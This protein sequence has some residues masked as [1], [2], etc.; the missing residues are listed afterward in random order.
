LLDFI[1]AT[2]LE[3]CAMN[4]EIMVNSKAAILDWM[5]G[6]SKTLGW[7]AL[8]AFDRATINTIFRERYIS[9]YGFGDAFPVISSGKEL[10]G[11]VARFF[12]ECVLGAPLLSFE[13]ADIVAPTASGLLEMN[14]LSGREMTID[15]NNG[16]R[17][18]KISQINALN[19]PLLQ[20]ELALQKQSQIGHVGVIAVD[21]A[22]GSKYT[23][24]SG[25]TPLET[26]LTGDMFKSVINDWPARLKYWVLNRVKL[27]SGPL[28][29]DTFSLRTQTAPGATDRS[30]ENYGDGAV[31]AFIK[32]KN[33]AAGTFPSS[34]SQLKYLIPSDDP[35]PYT[36]TTVVKAETFL[37]VAF[38]YLM[39]RAYEEGG[40]WMG[41]NNDNGYRLDENS[42]LPSLSFWGRVFS[43]DRSPRSVGGNRE[44]ASLSGDSYGFRMVWSI[45][46][47]AGCHGNLKIV[48]S[49]RYGRLSLEIKLIEMDKDINVYRQVDGPRAETLSGME[50]HRVKH[51]GVGHADFDVVLSNN[52]RS[53]SLS[54]VKSSSYSAGAMGKHQYNSSLAPWE[55]VEEALRPM[56]RNSLEDVIVGMASRELNLSL[57]PLNTFLFSPPYA[58]R[59][60]EVELPNDLVMFGHVAPQV[61]DFEITTPLHTMG[62]G[63]THAFETSG[64]STGIAWTVTSL[65][66]ELGGI[67]Q[68]NASSGHYTAPPAVDIPGL[69]VRVKVTAS[70]GEHSASA[71]VTVVRKEIT[72]N[73]L[74]QFTVAGSSLKCELSAGALDASGKRWGEID[75]ARGSLIPSTVAMREKSFVPPAEKLQKKVLDVVPVTVTAGGV[76][77]TAYVAVIYTPAT[78]LV[79]AAIT[80]TRSAQLSALYDGD[81]S[82]DTLWTVVAGSGEVDAATGLLHVPAAPAEPFVLVTAEEGTGGG[83]YFGGY[84]LLP[85]PLAALPPMPSTEPGAAEIDLG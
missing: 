21:L 25:A 46:P 49:G 17:L 26:E 22:S 72:I 8:L 5:K 42:T 47:E 15:Y 43:P 64:D 75:P 65:P 59:L 40:D 78:L 12:D 3:G 37:S 41:R 28:Q 84:I 50:Y 14:V 56:V 82:V 63:R 10:T 85:L 57:L 18:T 80:S 67:G 58:T 20:I 55:T 66:G 29:V 16:A 74:I 9:N 70:K 71:L 73:P 36:A 13:N 7:D 53:V 33:R 48:D 62:H 38:E 61:T 79:T 44:F 51:N 11:G 81:P 83:R 35:N 69:Q 4:D 39:N 77:E 34:A 30:A 32:L 24:S 31:V 2:I 68:I 1:L 45:Y 76:T 23:L 27:N 6:S 19:G 60:T 54:E 52:G